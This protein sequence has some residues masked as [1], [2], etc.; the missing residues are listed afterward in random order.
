MH[1]EIMN[2]G[3]HSDDHDDFGGLQRDLLATGAAINRR[4]LLR[5][6]ARFGVGVAALP[7]LGCGSNTPTSPSD[8]GSGGGSTSGGTGA[9]TAKV[10]EETQGPFPA[11]GSNGP[12]VL[13]L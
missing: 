5:L 7:L 13:S 4:G 11:D 9:C 12:S 6:A 8:T 3:Q 10:P 1:R 2:S